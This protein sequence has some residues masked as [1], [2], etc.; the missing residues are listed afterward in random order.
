MR[1]GTR[2][3]GATVLAAAAVVAVSG[4]STRAPESSG[5]GGGGAEAEDVTTDVGVEGTTI[6]L[7]VLTDL[8]GV[9][10]ALGQ[11]ITNGN[12]LYWD[13][14]QVCDTYD[15]ELVVQDT[16]YVP[17]TGVQL[18]SAMEPDV[19]AMQQ[20]IGSPINTALAPEFE[21]DVMTNFSSAWART[22]TEIPGTGVLGATYDVE[23]ANGYQYLFDQGLLADG[24]TVGHIY[25]EGEY[26]EN[27]LAGS[28]AVAEARG[29]TVIPAQIKSTDQDMSAQ[30]TQFAAEGVDAIV[31]TTAP[32][33]TASA[34]AVAQASGLDVPILGSNPVFAPGLLQG[35]SAQWLKDHL[36]VASPIT[37]WD[38]Q[39]ELLEAYQAAYPNTTPSL[40]VVF[41]YA[42]GDVMNQVLDA[43]CESGDL[44][45][46]GVQTAFGELSDIDTG[47]LLVPIEAFETG[48]SP[49]TQSFILRPAD[50]PGGA[51]LVQDAFEGEL[52]ADLAG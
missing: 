41:G 44:T 49:S 50:V 36:Y 43:A 23:L 29:L 33:Q 39:P 48:V 27:G 40:G 20:T 14:N 16:G 8:T 28:E 11:D 1:A 37:S 4:C 12:T 3:R 45:R 18:Y 46:E 42:M 38:T 2:L 7:G 47:G 35:P 22:L 21:S 51:E 13:E 25:F 52:S 34:A 30:V 9:F 10:A 5:G 17:Q 32:T 26:G 24:D 31:L 19:L 6:S 15:V